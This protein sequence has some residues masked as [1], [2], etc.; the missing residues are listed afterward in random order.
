[1]I[2]TAINFAW[3]SEMVQAD[4]NNPPVGSAAPA[5]THMPQVRRGIRHASVQSDKVTW[6]QG[7]RGGEPAEWSQWL[8]PSI[9]GAELRK[10]GRQRS[11]GRRARDQNELSVQTASQYTPVGLG[12]LGQWQSGRHP[13]AQPPGCHLLHQISQEFAVELDELHLLPYA[14][15]GSDHGRRP[16][17]DHDSAIRDS[18][19]RRRADRNRVEHR[20]HRPHRGRISGAGD[21]FVGSEAAYPRF[22][23]VVGLG[24]DAVAAAGGQ[25]GDETADAAA[26][27]GDQQA[28]A[29]RGL[30]R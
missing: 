16:S 5:H 30:L 28:G 2:V 22:V 10:A 12:C 27:P 3:R 18:G 26:G 1:M 9:S 25:L 14:T 6:A 17:G 24:Q 7:W 21:Y 19:G 15:L 23:L 11:P 4:Q 8:G 13:R 20:G 29:G